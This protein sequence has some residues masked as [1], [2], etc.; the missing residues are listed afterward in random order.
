MPKTIT[1]KEMRDYCCLF[2]R[3]S[4]CIYE[5]A[6][7]ENYHDITEVPEGKYD[8]LYLYGFG[9]REALEFY[10]QNGKLMLLSAMEIMLSSKPRDEIDAMSDAE[11]RKWMREERDK[12]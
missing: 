3:I 1:F 8:D 11:L 4:V 9:N 12:A 10:D 6:R 5:T 7:Y 2:D